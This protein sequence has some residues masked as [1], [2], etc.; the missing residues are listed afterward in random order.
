MVCGCYMLT[1]PCGLPCATS[2]V[3]IHH[4]G[5]GLQ[6]LLLAGL[7]YPCW[8]QAGHPRQSA[9][10]M[11]DGGRDPLANLASEGDEIG[12]HY[13]WSARNRKALTWRAH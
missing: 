11:E 1:V 2:A 9:C 5:C 3:D 13:A 12:P 6:G 4:H 8:R 7:F 10:V